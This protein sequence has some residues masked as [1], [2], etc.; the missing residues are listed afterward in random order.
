MAINLNRFNIPWRKQIQNPVT[1]DE[2]RRLRQQELVMSN[3]VEGLNESMA[4]ETEDSKILL[5]EESIEN[6]TIIRDNLSGNIQALEVQAQEKKNKEIDAFNSNVSFG[7]TVAIG[8][9]LQATRAYI[10]TI[11][12][13]TGNTIRQQTLSRN[14]NL[15][16]QAIGV[17]LTTIANPLLGGAAAVA[18]VSNIAIR[19]YTSSLER[20]RATKDNAMRLEL[21]DGVAQ[22]GNR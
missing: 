21:L 17:A 14:L 20:Q 9:A 8:V 6:S 12:I 7:A 13:R 4:R 10:S 5:L 16:T 15:G 1:T 11:G 22:R 2:T 18:F 3:I 19:E